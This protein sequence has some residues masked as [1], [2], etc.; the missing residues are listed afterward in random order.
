MKKLWMALVALI[1]VLVAAGCFRDNRGEVDAKP[2]IYLYPKETT[3]VH[4]KLDY[5]GRLTCTWPE[6]ADGWTVT[7]RPDGSLTT[8]DGNS[9]SY[10]F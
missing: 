3:Q 1:M 6:Y 8:E 5:N 7:A 9:Y 2:V 10:L 4:V